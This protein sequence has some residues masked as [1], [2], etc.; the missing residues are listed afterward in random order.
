ME[1][2]YLVTLIS[3]FVGQIQTRTIEV[4][5]LSEDDAKDKAQKQTRWIATSIR[6]SL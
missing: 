6:A 5:A 1:S 2:K 4:F 3:D